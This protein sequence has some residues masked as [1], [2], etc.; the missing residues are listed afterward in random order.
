MT[1]HTLET[2]TTG[3]SWGCRFRVT[4]FVNDEGQP[5]DAPRNLQPGEAHPG[6]VGEYESIGV[7]KIR[8]ITNQKVILVDTKTQ[9]EFSVT[10]DSCWDIDR[11]EYAD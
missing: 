2:I 3:E 10:W 9:R 8:D 4:T 5:V 1:E 11:V 7:I 6:T